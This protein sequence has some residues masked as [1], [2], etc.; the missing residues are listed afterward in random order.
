[1]ASSK[2]VKKIIADYYKSILLKFEMKAYN[3]L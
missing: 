2:V 3:E 1:M